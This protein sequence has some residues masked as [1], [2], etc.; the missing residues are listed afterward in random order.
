[1][2]RRAMTMILLTAL[3]AASS[4]MGSGDFEDLAQPMC[5]ENRESGYW[6]LNNGEREFVEDLNVHNELAGGC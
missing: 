5:L 1:M 6:L 2:L 3:L 4:C